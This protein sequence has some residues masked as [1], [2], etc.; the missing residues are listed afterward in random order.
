MATKQFAIPLDENSLQSG[1]ITIEALMDAAAAATFQLSYVSS[2]GTNQLNLK[3]CKN[4]VVKNHIYACTIVDGSASVKLSTEQI[5]DVCE[6]ADGGDWDYVET[7]WTMG[8]VDVGGTSNN[9]QIQGG[10][11]YNKNGWPPKTS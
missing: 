6:D 10:T 7:E 4:S 9:F 8:G 2:G 3:T 11:T 5:K 1:D